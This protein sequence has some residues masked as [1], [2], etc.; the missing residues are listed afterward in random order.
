MYASQVSQNQGQIEY[1]FDLHRV[2]KGMKRLEKSTKIKKDYE[3]ERIDVMKEK[4]EEKMEL[5]KTN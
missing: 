3:K 1:H 5:A 4:R 2:H